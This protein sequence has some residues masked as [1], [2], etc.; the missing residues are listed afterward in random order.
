MFI[1]CPLGGNLL[2]EENSKTADAHY[3]QAQELIKKGQDAKA[4]AEATQAIKLKANYWE[5]YSLRGIAY[6]RTGDFDKAIADLSEA[7]RLN[8]TDPNGYKNRAIIY[9][10]KGD[11]EKALADQETVNKLLVK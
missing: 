8:P 9:G 1:L 3:K 6:A 11:K 4:I 2:A 5:A 7:I 10:M